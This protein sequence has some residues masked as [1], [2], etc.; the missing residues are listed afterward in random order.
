[1]IV[2]EAW[3]G[4]KLQARAR[5][6]TSQATGAHVSVLGQITLEELRRLVTETQ[7][8]NGFANRHLFACARRARLLPA[9]GNIDEET[10]DRFGGRLRLALERAR[11]I[12]RLQRSAEAETRWAELYHEMAED[13]PGGLLGSVIDRAEAQTLRLSVV[14]ALLDGSRTIELPHLEA[15]WAVWCYCRQSAAHI[16]G[17]TLGD[18]TADRLLE[19][20]RRAGSDG[21]DGTQERNLFHRHASGAD[22]ERARRLLEDRGHVVTETRKTGGRD[23]RVTRAVDHATEATKATEVQRFDGS[24]VA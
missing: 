15:A 12:T 20:Y 6:R 19:A 1:M 22:L 2:R 17:N 21:L 10:I 3:D 11:K 9:G 14:Y 4:G 5:Q 8:A 16:F 7:M 13:D 23:R 18:E 24:W